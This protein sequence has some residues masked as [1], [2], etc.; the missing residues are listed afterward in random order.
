MIKNL[1][2]SI[3]E[4]LL[5][6]NQYQGTAALGSEC[7]VLICFEFVLKSE[8]CI[9]VKFPRLLSIY[10][11]SPEQYLFCCFSRGGVLTLFERFITCFKQRE[12]KTQNEYVRFLFLK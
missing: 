4:I 3:Y 6:I 7:L 12:E 10:C 1:N 9:C 11:F 5:V 8:F 2:S